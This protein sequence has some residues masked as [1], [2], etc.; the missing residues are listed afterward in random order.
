MEH[1]DEGGI[2]RLDALRL[3]GG[4][5]LF[6]C[7]LPTDMC[8]VLESFRRPLKHCLPD[9]CLGPCMPVVGTGQGLIVRFSGHLHTSN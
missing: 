9:L 8:Q 7:P 2:V 4:F 1:L 6:P 3:V 5:L